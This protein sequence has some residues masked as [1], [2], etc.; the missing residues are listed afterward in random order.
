LRQRAAGR[1]A[2]SSGAA[3]VRPRC[4]GGVVRRTR[5]ATRSRIASSLSLGSWRLVRI[6]AADLIGWLPCSCRVCRCYV[7]L[8]W[9]LPLPASSM[10]A[11]TN[12]ARRFASIILPCAQRPKTEADL[13]AADR[14]RA[15]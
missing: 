2:G 14:W 15:Q 4:G 10:A 3:A 12:M 13:Q 6:P 7:A 1:Q 9:T 11:L 5:N 8:R